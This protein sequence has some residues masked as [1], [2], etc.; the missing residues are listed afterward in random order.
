MRF[1]CNIWGGPTIYFVIA[2]SYLFANECLIKFTSTV[3]FVVIDT[4]KCSCPFFDS[5]FLRSL[6]HLTIELIFLN[7]CLQFSDK[8]IMR[9]KA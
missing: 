1:F 9:G 7:F 4:I 8:R 2:S 3:Q 5:H 6:L